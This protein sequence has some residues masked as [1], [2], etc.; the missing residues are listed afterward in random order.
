MRYMC[1]QCSTATLLPGLFFLLFGRVS[2]HF[3]HSSCCSLD[4]H[5]RGFVSS[6]SLPS[7]RRFLGAIVQL[8][9][10]HVRLNF[11]FLCL[12]KGFPAIVTPCVPGVVPPHVFTII[13]S[14]SRSPLRSIRGI[15]LLQSRD[16]LIGLVQTAGGDIFVIIQVSNAKQTGK[17]HLR[18]LSRA[19]LFTLLP[20]SSPRFLAGVS[21]IPS[22]RTV[23]ELSGQVLPR[24]IRS[25]S[26]H[27]PPT[28]HL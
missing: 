24:V 21:S 17:P 28:A 13:I 7:L 15:C 5:V 12:P 2:L 19:L 26:R 20:F 3:L 9:S 1:S 10:F 4:I 25:S 6:P 11:P 27:W 22:P 23:G 16:T 14:V 8:V 18:T